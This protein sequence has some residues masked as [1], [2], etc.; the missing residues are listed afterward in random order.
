MANWFNIN[1]FGY[2]KWPKEEKRIT[3]DGKCFTLCPLTKEKQAS[4]HIDLEAERI[5]LDDSA[6]LMNKFLS[7]LS[8]FSHQPYWL[9]D[10]FS[11]GVQKNSNFKREQRMLFEGMIVEFPDEFELHHNI[12][13][14]QALAFYRD[15]Q[16]SKLY[17]PA[18]ACLAFYKILEIEKKNNGLPSLTRW[19]DEQMPEIKKLNNHLVQEL[20]NSACNK[21]MNISEYLFKEVRCGAAHYITDSEINL[22][23]MSARN[24][25]RYATQPLEI[26]ADYYIR[27]ELGISDHIFSVSPC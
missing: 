27:K 8:W 21:N 7:H 6:T 19:I 3:I 2:G 4:M 17:S 25:F 1:V 23:D 11:G 12:L 10:G 13:H 18:N 5:S 20:E 24:I 16:I 9:G 22:D 15:G 14:L 26:L